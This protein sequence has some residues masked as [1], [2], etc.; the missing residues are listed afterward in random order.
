[1]LYIDASDLGGWDTQHQ[2]DIV[3]MGNKGAFRQVVRFN[4]LQPAPTT[5]KPTPTEEPTP[6]PTTEEP[7]VMLTTE[8]ST[9][10]PTSEI[11]IPTQSIP[12]AATHPWFGSALFLGSGL[13]F[14]TLVALLLRWRQTR[15]S[16]GSK[17]AEATRYQ[18][19]EQQQLPPGA[20]IEMVEMTRIQ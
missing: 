7:T 14:I 6:A 4:P 11:S 2:M 12:L 20:E 18:W 15:T 5:E 19:N 17:L 10:A 8:K 3:V 9:M 13:V 1:M 16:S